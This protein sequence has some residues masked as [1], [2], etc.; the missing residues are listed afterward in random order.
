MFCLCLP[1]HAAQTQIATTRSKMSQINEKILVSPHNQWE[2][3][4]YLRRPWFMCF[5]AIQELGRSHDGMLLDTPANHPE[6]AV[7]TTEGLSQQRYNNHRI[8]EYIH[9][10]SGANL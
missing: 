3:S 2:G 4:R 7:M 9:C 1:G 10:Y 5:L 6:A 8:R